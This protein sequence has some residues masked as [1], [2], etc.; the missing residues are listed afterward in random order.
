MKFGFVIPQNWGLSDPQDV[1]QF[2]VRAEELGYDSVWVNHHILNVGYIY[3]RLEDRPYYDAL[4]VLT[5]VAARTERVRLGTTVLVLPYLNPLVLAKTI[6]TLDMMSGGRVSLGV[7]VGMLREENEALGSDFTTRG[8]YADESIEVLRD[9]WTSDD[10]SHSGRFFDYEG[11]KFSPKPVQSPGVPILIGGMSRAAM[12]RTARLGDGWHPNGGT[13]SELGDRFDVVKTM[14][15][16]FDR[17]PNELSLV[18]RGELKVLDTPSEDPAT[19]M[20]GTPDQ[21]LRSIEAY[22]SIGVSEIVLQVGTDDVDH[23]RRAQ[24][25]FAEQ[26]LPRVTG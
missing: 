16:E 6:A 3:D 24:E 11:F 10:P 15:A 19:P 12:R 14:C 26:V 7:G 17:D 23:I 20:I 9:L 13:V 5:W 1:V 18:V 8:A 25:S 2:G 21:L 4:T 22:E